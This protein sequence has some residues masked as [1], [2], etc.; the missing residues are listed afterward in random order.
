MD[1]SNK[2]SKKTDKKSSYKNEKGIQPKKKNR[3]RLFLIIS[4]LFL[5]I[6]CLPLSGAAYM[7]HQ[8]KKTV[9]S[10]QQIEAK[11][12]KPQQIN[13]QTDVSKSANPAQPNNT[14][15]QSQPKS[16]GNT[17]YIAPVCTK[18]TLPA[19]V[20]YI[21]VDWLFVGEVKT[22]PGGDGWKTTCTPDSNGYVP[23]YTDYA[24]YPTK[25]YRGTKQVQSNPSYSYS[26][27]LSTAQGQC[28]PIALASG[29]GSSAYQQ[30]ISAVLTQYGY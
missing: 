20:E 14:Q 24:G 19:Q 28:S 7:Y 15:T 21:D 25:V 12:T 26:Y 3:F 17:P 29:S 2:A 18:V 22:Y 30:C 5:L 4:L 8:A 16:A 1:K 27:A 10:T 11:Q 6:Y 9:T 23:Q 13:A